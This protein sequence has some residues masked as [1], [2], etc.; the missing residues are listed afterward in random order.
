[1]NEN[2]RTEV[3]IIYRY[4]PEET[5]ENHENVYIRLSDTPF[6]IGTSHHQSAERYRCSNLFGESFSLSKTNFSLLEKNS[7]SGK[8]FLF[9]ETA[10]R[11]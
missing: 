6:K 10:D 11:I 4:L 5:E 8:E 1:L 2:G 3:E 9:S 7:G